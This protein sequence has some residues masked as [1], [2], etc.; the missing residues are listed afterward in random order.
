M[1]LVTVMITGMIF[2]M[3]LS[4]NVAGRM[5][6]GCDGFTMRPQ[7][8]C[9]AVLAGINCTAIMAILFMVVRTVASLNSGGGGFGGGGF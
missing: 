4:A 7:T 6:G 9:Q 3:C 5:Y 8:P 2:G 1:S